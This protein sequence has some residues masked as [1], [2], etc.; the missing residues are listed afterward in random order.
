MGNLRECPFCGGNAELSVHR[1]AVVFVQC[2]QC[3]ATFPMFDS[4]KEAIDAW[5]RRVNCSDGYSRKI[6]EELG[7]SLF[8]SDANE[9]ELKEC[10][11]EFEEKIEKVRKE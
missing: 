6:L 1:G 10:Q 11:K 8:D 7:V 3:D 5:N 4:E 9:R 2:Q